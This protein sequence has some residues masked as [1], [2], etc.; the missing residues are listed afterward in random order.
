VK[1]HDSPFLPSILAYVLVTYDELYVVPFHHT[2]AESDV[3]I[4]K[5]VALVVL[6]LSL[7]YI[8]FSLV[9]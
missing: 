5:L 9:Q 6:N 4:L 8:V 3:N 1:Y 7:A 2:K